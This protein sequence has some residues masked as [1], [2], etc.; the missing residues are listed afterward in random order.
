MMMTEHD[1]RQTAKS[2]Y[3]Q[4]YSVA[5][6]AKRLGVST[7]T[8]YSW[9]R[10][11]KWD[12]A[13]PVTRVSD[14]LHVKILRIQAKDTL[15]PHDFKTLDF[16][17]RQLERFDKND[18]KKEEKKKAKTPK[19]HFSDEQISEL[20]ALVY[21]SLYEYQKRWY[22]QRERRNRMILK[23]RQI[24]A[25][26]YFAR[27]ALITA[28]ETG[29]NQIFLS[30]SRS[31]AH[32]FKIFI[33]IVA[34][35]VGVELKGGDEIKLSN[36]ATL[37]FLGTSAAHAQ[38]YTGDLYFDE[39]FWVSNFMNLR[40]VAA[41][42]ATHI[43][44]RRTY[45]STPSSE[46][47]E[48]YPFWTGEFFNQSQP[49][50]KQIEIDTSHAALQ[51]G[52]LCGDNIW[53]QIVTI[54]DAIALG[55]DR[56]DLEEIESENSPADF[57]NLYRCIFV[58]AGERAFDY[59][60]LI[61][62]GVDGYNE[63]VWP[64][65]R[66]YAPRPLGN[67]PV[68]I[69]ADPTGTGGNGDG[70]GLVVMSPPAVSGGKWRV[71]ESLQFR[72]MAFEKQADEIRKLTGRYHVQGITIDGTGGTGEAVHELVCKFFP[73]A[74]L[75]KYSAP[76]KRMLVMKA[77]MLIRSGRFEY[78]AGMKQVA[79]S[80]MSIKKIITQGGVVTYDADRTRGIDHGDIAW[81][82]MNVLYGE[83]ISSDSGGHT[84]FVTEF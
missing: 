73:A 53:R 58:K 68:Y 56:V 43:G 10:R 52:A 70:L 22:M 50:K 18:A 72:G 5:Q 57:D 45:I 32:Q 39:I 3:W 61:S 6:I 49:H 44:L 25:T 17:Y 55:L 67:K 31:Q 84:S 15:T 2:L 21:D 66:P 24:G 20:R 28:L 75:L 47:H 13:H 34:R 35:Q 74:T 65:W 62:C 64:D 29:N 23:S 77:Q 46:E 83:P 80:F 79:T 37:Y 63:D 59:N 48:A 81:A 19:N 42:M 11:D 30:A 7:N 12:E 38:S 76:L 40:K 41:G 4:A 8:I 27:E 51:S 26:W 33:Q 16:L 71:I 69:G 36:G 1:P 60:G 9:R 78:D 54:Y 82:I 14:D